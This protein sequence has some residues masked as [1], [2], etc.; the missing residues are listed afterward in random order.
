MFS[1]LF[2]LMGGLFLLNNKS[3]LEMHFN[4]YIDTNEVTNG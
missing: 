2:C 3:Y 4:P 1:L